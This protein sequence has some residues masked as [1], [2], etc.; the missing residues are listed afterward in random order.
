MGE[1]D[2]VIGI[3]S[4]SAAIDAFFIVVFAGIVRI[5]WRYAFL[6]GTGI[7]IVAFTGALAA[8]PDI[9]ANLSRPDDPGRRVRRRTRRPW[10]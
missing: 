1:W 4:L 8:A 9:P 10:L 2:G 7:A 3:A 5:P 6:I